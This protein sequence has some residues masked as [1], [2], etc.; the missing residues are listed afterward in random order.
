MGRRVL[1][2]RNIAP[3]MGG[4]NARGCRG[5]TDNEATPCVAVL[6]PLKIRAHGLE[7]HA[8]GRKRASA[9]DSLNRFLR[10]LRSVEMT[11][12]CVAALGRNDD[13][14][15][16]GSRIVRAVLREGAS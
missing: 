2:V 5:L 1:V 10:S 3:Y 8:T 15:K 14:G 7:A 9:G 4:N 16:N 12:W 13:G 6:Y 11:V